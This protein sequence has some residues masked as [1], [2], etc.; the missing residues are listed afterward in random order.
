MYMGGEE[1]GICLDTLQT[2][3]QWKLTSNETFSPLQKHV[4]AAFLLSS[5]VAWV[6]SSTSPSQMSS[7][8]TF[9]SDKRFTISISSYPKCSD[10]K[11]YSPS[12][13]YSW[14]SLFPP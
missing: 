5:S 9:I 1:N 14:N 7:S 6:H 13:H 11:R 2:L 3:L 10:T 4:L 8:Q 12:N